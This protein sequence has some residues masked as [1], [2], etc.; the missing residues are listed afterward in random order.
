MGVTV[1][2]LARKLA[3]VPFDD[4]IVVLRKEPD[5][6]TKGGL[7]IPETAREKP[8]VG[9]V[10]SVGRNVKDPLVTVGSWVM[11]LAYAGNEVSLNDELV[12]VMRYEEI[13]GMLEVPPEGGE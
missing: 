13:L 7:V 10:V 5:A 6:V 3:F 12:I 1:Q 8:C 11:F 4:R 2:K 9:Q